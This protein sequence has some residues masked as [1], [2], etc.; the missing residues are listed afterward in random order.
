MR[1]HEKKADMF[2]YGSGSS[3]NGAGSN[4]LKS[5]NGGGGTYTFGVGPQVN[6]SAIARN[7]SEGSGSSS[8]SS[9]GSGTEV[10]LTNR[11]N[12]S[13][14]SSRSV[15]NG[16]IATTSSSTSNGDSAAL[17]HVAWPK[18]IFNCE[19]ESHP[20]ITR[21]VCIKDVVKIGRAIVGSKV[22]LDT[23]L[24]DS[25]VLSRYHAILTYR[26]CKVS[27]Y[28]HFISFFV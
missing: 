18:A 3:R 23:C 17:N 28:L 5:M 10:V 1:N 27:E 21:E 4:T 6:S 14:A 25:R 26:D 24:F 11:F 22:S 8:R 9:S 7:R 19:K 16:I 12:N 2:K 15:G 13:G 20:F